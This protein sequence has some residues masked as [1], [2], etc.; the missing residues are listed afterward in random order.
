[1]Q[2]AWQLLHKQI[3]TK[4]LKCSTNSYKISTDEQ[5]QK[6][7]FINRF[8]KTDTEQKERNI[9][10]VQMGIIYISN[11]V[12]RSNIYVIYIKNQSNL[13]SE[14]ITRGCEFCL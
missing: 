11:Q 1:M 8:Y 3:D 9:S 4:Y 14:P 10:I 7:T 2:V 12:T 13:P 5:K 6:I